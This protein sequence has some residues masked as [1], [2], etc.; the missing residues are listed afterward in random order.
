M[1]KP[2]LVHSQ[3]VTCS[4]MLTWTRGEG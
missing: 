2:K 4:V 3:N 1:P